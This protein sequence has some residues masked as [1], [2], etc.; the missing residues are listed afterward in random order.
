MTRTSPLPTPLPRPRPRREERD[1]TDW[2]SAAVSPDST[3]HPPT[4]RL[5]RFGSSSRA[6]LWLGVGF[7]CLNGSSS[8][9]SR[10]GDVLGGSSPPHPV[11]SQR[12]FPA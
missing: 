3:P 7:E 8:H 6:P 5:V 12:R 1:G 10:L 11:L 9:P 4:P 2:L